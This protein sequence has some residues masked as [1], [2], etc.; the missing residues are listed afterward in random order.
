VVI[1]GNWA[2]VGEKISKQN[3][4]ANKSLF[5]MQFSPFLERNLRV[6]LAVPQ[7]EMEP[8]RLAAGSSVKINW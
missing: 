7:L 1:K 6:N 3:E 8:R 4:I 5:V 2:E